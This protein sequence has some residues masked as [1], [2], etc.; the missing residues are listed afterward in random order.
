MSLANTIQLPSPCSRLK[1]RSSAMGR[2]GKEARSSRSSL[3][4]F[5]WS[6]FCSSATLVQS[7]LAVVVLW[8]ERFR[9]MCHQR[10]ISLVLRRCLVSVLFW[11]RCVSC[12]PKGALPR[13][14]PAS[15]WVSIQITR[16]RILLT[17]LVSYSSSHLSTSRATLRY[18]RELEQVLRAACFGHLRTL[19][20][21]GPSPDSTELLTSGGLGRQRSGSRITWL[22]SQ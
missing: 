20:S 8:Q 12:Y 22:M 18:R 7:I 5:Q 15:A 11:M 16:R 19:L 14:M 3:V 9:S 2:I 21:L 13:A 17:R 10:L 4:R 1:N 6:M